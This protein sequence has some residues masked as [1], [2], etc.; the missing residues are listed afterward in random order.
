MTLTKLISIVA[1]G[2]TALH[3]AAHAQAQNYPDKPVQYV[4]PFPPGGESDY[5]ARLQAELFKTKYK[6]SMVVLNKA[7][8]GGGL[9]WGQLNSMPADGYTI[10][11]VNLPHIVLQP[12]EGSVQ[13]K[14]D[15]ITPVYFYHFT[16]D[17]LVVPG[18][19][20]FKTYQDLVK[21]A[22]EKP[23][24]IN[25]AGSGSLS[26]N[27][28]AHERF[29]KQAGVKTTYVPFKGTGDLISSMLGS[30]VD[31]AMTYL[32]F[33]IQQ[34]G[35]MRL[36]AVASEKRHPAFPDVPTF[37]EVGLD[38][39]DGAYRGVAVPKSTPKDIQKKISDIMADLNSDPDM[40]KKLA[41][42]GFDIVDI[43]VDKMP[44]FMAQRSKVYLQDAKDAGLGKK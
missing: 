6:Q 4:I 26:A 17:A 38:W 31:A 32:P 44:E 20:P 37:K 5:V 29:N 8:A 40:R 39:V 9:V 43:S 16:A 22:K 2:L 33:A 36:L 7:G 30:H 12:L 24:S 25:I 1:L 15:D 41:D 34:K 27:H 19:S 18:N 28:M 3:P 35:K 23:N 21:A 10:A 13:Y 14:T 42:G 11:G